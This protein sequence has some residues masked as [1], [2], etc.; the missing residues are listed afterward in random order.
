[1]TVIDKATHMKLKELGKEK[2]ILKVCIFEGEYSDI[3]IVIKIEQPLN[4][5]IKSFEINEKKGTERT[6][7]N[8]VFKSDS[9]R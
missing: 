3:K 7:T 6:N 1:M 5:S 8:D 4:I 2:T 9:T